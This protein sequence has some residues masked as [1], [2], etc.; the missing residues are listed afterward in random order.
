MSRPLPLFVAVLLALAASGGAG[1]RV[2]A[3]A[4]DGPPGPPPPSRVDLVDGV[5]PRPRRALHDAVAASIAAKAGV[6]AVAVRM[7]RPLLE[8]VF[9]C[10]HLYVDCDADERTGLD[11]MDLWV[12]AAFGSRYQRANAPPPAPGAPAPAGLRRGSYSHPH[13][14]AERDGRARTTWIHV[15]GGEIAPPDVTADTIA[16]AVPL[17]LLLAQG[18]R[19][20]RFV[21]VRLEVEG[22]LSEHPISL[23]YVC[24]DEGT[25]MLADGKPDEWSGQ[26][27]VRD[28]TGDL[29]EDVAEI[30]LASLAVDHDADRVHALVRL[31]GPGFNLPYEDADVD[32][33]DT[34]TVA[35]EP[36]ATGGRY[37]DYVEHAVRTRVSSRF[38]AAGD[39]VV[40]FSIPRAPPQTAFRVVAWADAI[41]VDRIP[42]RGTVDVGV[43]PEAFR[44]GEAAR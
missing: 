31:A 40:E 7:R 1:P 14:Q 26:P 9:T 30:D 23:T 42:D 38:G 24:A 41:R 20:N 21:R 18:L 2:V 44:P 28:A 13:T 10:V 27:S 29:H 8:G 35:L 15:R 5:S 17:T 6:L 16:F 43:P 33:R 22:G 4:A 39:R 25:P 37:M 3:R 34:V 32:D 11:G 36:L 12:R 19:Y